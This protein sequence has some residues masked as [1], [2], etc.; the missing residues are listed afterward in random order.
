MTDDCYITRKTLRNFRHVFDFS[1]K[2]RLS[3]ERRR[4]EGSFLKSLELEIRM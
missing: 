4:L 1:F 2:K 3:N